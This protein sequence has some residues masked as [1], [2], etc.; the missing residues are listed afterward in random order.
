MG[1][2]ARFEV[3]R[4]QY[5]LND[6]R[7]TL[8]E[9]F[10]PPA[11]VVASVAGRDRF[12]GQVY[13]KVGQ[14]RGWGFTVHVDADS[15]T[16]A[17]RI[18]ETLQ[19]FLDRAGNPKQP[20]YFAYRDWGS[21]YPFE[22][23][24]GQFGKLDRFKVLAGQVDFSQ[25]YELVYEDAQLIACPV[26]LTIDPYSYGL[27]QRLATAAGGVFEHVAGY[28]DGRSRGVRVANVLTGDENKMTNPIFGHSTW[29]TGWTAGANVDAT[30]NTDPAHVLFGYSSARLICSAATLNT[31][32]QS[33][34]VG[35]TN[36][37]TVSCY[38]Q[39]GNKDYQ[40]PLSEGSF[41]N[42]V[43]AG[44]TLTTRFLELEDGWWLLSAQFT[45]I[46]SAQAVGVILGNG[47][48]VYVDGFQ[49]EQ[50]T[51][52]N[53]LC[54]GGMPGHSWSGTAHNSSTQRTAAGKLKINTERSKAEGTIQVVVRWMARSGDLANGLYYLF[55][56]SADEFT[57]Y[58][59]KTNNR[60]T[61]TDGTNTINSAATPGI[62]DVYIFHIGWK[63]TQLSMW[64]NGAL[65]GNA[66][67][68]ITTNKP[69]GFYVGSTSM[70]A[71]HGPFAFMGFEVYPVR[72][73][74]TQITE[75]YDQLA[76][77]Y[78][79]PSTTTED[80][81]EPISPLPYFWTKDGDD[82]VDNHDDSGED[83]WG[84][85]GGVP[86]SAEAETEWVI[87]PSVGTKEG[88]WLMRTWLEYGR[89][90]QPNEIWYAD[91]SGTADVGNA[92]GDA[93]ERLNLG[94]TALE[95][96]G[97]ALTDASLV[98]KT[99]HVFARAKVASGQDLLAYASVTPGTSQEIKSETRRVA[100]TTSYKW[101]Y[102]G[103]VYFEY[104]RQLLDQHK[105]L[106]VYIWLATLT[107]NVNGDVDYLMAINGAVLRI[108]NQSAATI[109]RLNILGREAYAA[110]SSDAL[111]TPHIT[112]GDEVHLLP[113]VHNLVWF[114]LGDD[115]EAHTHTNTAT[116]TTITIRPRWLLQ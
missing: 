8:A 27:R 35:N 109:S 70:G 28:M 53:P 72:M 9:G 110:N 66:N 54:H 56:D 95:Y 31:F 80:V 24:W 13:E 81:I 115:G 48:E 30:R 87:S 62:G 73:E 69:N 5:P 47:T 112:I 16:E 84:L 97:V 39:L 15:E 19:L 40:D 116:F 7:I 12:S 43:Y 22:P 98:E 52:P 2:M 71:S 4:K 113:G 58:Y 60:F 44:S 63:Y 89:F 96:G 51:F 38:A 102:I 99:V 1:L 75:W 67:Y 100:M 46:A 91:L 41:I 79:L 25:M 74:Q 21:S 106:R 18:L 20:L 82:V 65:A 6:G 10:V 50:N 26:T 101:F 14:P 105:D 55:Q 94:T 37:H 68:A 92:S 29:N 114:V 45:G 59:D 85:V 86:G 32:T 104:P 64:V 3:G 42:L 34:N 77:I 83:N 93:V 90:Q 111:I 107:G 61:F 11:T 88:Y 36:Q 23:T 33:I 49:V 17:K 108:K 57:L 103:T 78:F 76:A